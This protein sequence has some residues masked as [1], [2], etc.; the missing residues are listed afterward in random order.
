MPKQGKLRIIGGKWK[1]R[2]ISFPAILDLRPTPDS[3]R[4]TLFN[5]LGQDL[6]GQTCLDLF[7]GSGALGFEA[8]S[9][10]ASR[11]DLVELNKT[12]S[13]N[14]QATALQIDEDEIIYVHTNNA[15]SYVTTCNR[16]YD[17]VFLDPPFRKDILESLCVALNENNRLNKNAQIYIESPRSKLPLPIPP[18]WNIIREAT[19]GMVKSTLIQITD[20]KT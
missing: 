12:A 5:W 10:G 1:R 18:T 16:A 3:V 15:M 17:V 14:L 7:A 13:K 11:V 19:R 2:Q 20:S 8:A 4:E 9:R 6:S